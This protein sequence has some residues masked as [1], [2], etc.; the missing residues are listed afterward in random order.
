MY[1]CV[2]NESGRDTPLVISSDTIPNYQATATGSSPIQDASDGEEM[3]ILTISQLM[4][5]KASTPSSVIR[6]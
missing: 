3:S 4:R 6:P 5:R 2:D 1:L